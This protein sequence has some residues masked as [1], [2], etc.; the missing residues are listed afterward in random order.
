MTPNHQMMTSHNKL[1]HQAHQ[2]TLIVRMI[3]ATIEE[4]FQLTKLTMTG[5]RRHTIIMTRARIK[6]NETKKGWP[7]SS[8]A[9]PW[10][11]VDGSLG[12][13]QGL[14]GHSDGCT[15]LKYWRCNVSFL[16]QKNNSKSYTKSENINKCGEET[17]IGDFYTQPLQ[18]KNCL[19]FRSHILS[20]QW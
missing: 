12:I 18:G 7:P 13:H 6:R 11:C 3:M 5:N 4:T 2:A 15:L 1:I 20:L 16:K 9:V 19:G 17:M 14:E 10:Q 8:S